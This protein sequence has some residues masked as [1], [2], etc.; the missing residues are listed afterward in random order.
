[1]PA[2]LMIRGAVIGRVPIVRV[3]IAGEAL[4]LAKRAIAERSPC[5]RNRVVFTTVTILPVGALTRIRLA[6]LHASQTGVVGIEAIG[7]GGELAEDSIE[8]GVQL[9][10]K[11]RRIELGDGHGCRFTQ[12][13]L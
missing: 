13:G 1:M 4:P 12:N 9:L 10:L 5:V 6:G 3:E 7:D 8:I 2:E 11:G